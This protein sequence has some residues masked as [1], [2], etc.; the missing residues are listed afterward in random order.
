MLGTP[1][2]HRDDVGNDA[3]DLEAPFMGVKPNR[4]LQVH[5][6]AAFGQFSGEGGLDGCVAE[7]PLGLGYAAVEVVSGG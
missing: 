7:G 5:G 1:I 6:V 3:M 4:D 2:Y